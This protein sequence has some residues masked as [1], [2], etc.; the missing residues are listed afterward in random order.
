MNAEKE[1]EEVKKQVTALRD[2]IKNMRASVRGLLNKAEVMQQSPEWTAYCEAE[3]NDV[4]HDLYIDD[5]R[6]ELNLLYTG[7]A[8]HENEFT[9]IIS[10]LKQ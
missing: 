10:N 5:L 6:A 9:E 1:F 2:E 8:Y 3:A 4:L 7:A